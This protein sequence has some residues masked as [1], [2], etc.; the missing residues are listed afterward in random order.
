MRL[1]HV[2]AGAAVWSAVASAAFVRGSPGHVWLEWRFWPGAA[3]AGATKNAQKIS[4]V[5]WMNAGTP[6]ACDGVLFSL[7]TVAGA[8]RLDVVG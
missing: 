5:R 6:L 2:A 7:H 4:F 8:L 3:P 1:L